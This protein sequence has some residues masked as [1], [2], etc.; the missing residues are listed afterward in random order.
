MVQQKFQYFNIYM[1]SP[2][3]ADHLLWECKL[4]GWQRQVLRNSITK[5]GEKLANDQL[6]FGIYVYKISFKNFFEPHT[7][8]KFI[9]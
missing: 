5:V 2:Q 1:L 6:W 3:T 4:L 8:L 9:N 7:F